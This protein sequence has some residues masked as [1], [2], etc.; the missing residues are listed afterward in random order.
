MTTSPRRTLLRNLLAV[1]LPE[2]VWGF[3]SALTIESPI[4]AAFRGY[5]CGGEWFLGAW[6]LVGALA[7]AAAMLL[8]SWFVQGLARKR[9]FVVVG[10]LVTG[11]L[12]LPVILLARALGDDENGA[13]QLGALVGYG[14]FALSLGFLMP[15]WMALIGALFP[16]GQRA[17][18]LG[19][20]FALNRI[21]G[22]LGGLAAEAVLRS[23][24]DLHDQWTWLWGVAAGM[25]MLGAL[26]FLWVVEPQGRAV[27]RPSLRAHLGGLLGALRRLPDLRRFVVVDL[28]AVTGFVVLAYYGDMAFGVRGLPPESAGGLTAISAG[29]QL[30]GALLVAVAGSWLRP[31]RALAFGALAAGG[32]AVLTCVAST[33]FAFAGVAALGG[34]FLVARQTCHGPQVMRLAGPGDP[35][36]SLA[37]AMA[38]GSL[39]Q[40][41]L[42]FAAGALR[43]VTGFPP[44]FM[45]VAV[46]TLLGALLLLLRVGDAPSRDVPSP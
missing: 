13:S 23:T 21:G 32:A 25:A 27:P 35:T 11:A 39:G 3:G 5:L 9:A 36:A 19:L 44:V 8:T 26:P 10:H 30:A 15:A 46:L 29:A 12:Y 7:S 41:L 43:P 1:T 16:E 45:T 37:L 31:R 33:P 24:W 22:V 6:T 2:L 17:R 18:V 20:I 34:L 40:A 38:V 14:L 28:L 42:P 4:P